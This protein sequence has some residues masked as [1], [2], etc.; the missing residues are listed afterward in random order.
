MSNTNGIKHYSDFEVLSSQPGIEAAMHLVRANALE[1][2]ASA[3]RM[4]LKVR[5]GS[6]AGLDLLWDQPSVSWVEK[7]K[8]A[9]DHVCLCGAPVPSGVEQCHECRDGFSGAELA[10]GVE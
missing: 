9:L 2:G 1:S 3:D 7:A 8:P 10:Q 6:L 4:F 5:A